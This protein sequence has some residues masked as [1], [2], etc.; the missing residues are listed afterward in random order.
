MKK[1][2]FSKPLIFFFWEGRCD[3]GCRYW[4]CG[5]EQKY[6][7]SWLKRTKTL[8]RF[9]LTQG[10]WTA[11]FF[12]TPCQWKCFATCFRN[13]DILPINS[14]TPYNSAASRAVFLIPKISH[15]IRHCKFV[16][17][18]GCVFLK[19]TQT[20]CSFQMGTK[21]P[22]KKI[23]IVVRSFFT[24]WTTANEKC[25]RTHGIMNSFIFQCVF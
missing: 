16:L 20:T 15:V 23:F 17:P 5:K 4:I 2:M 14:V 6:H 18:G 9:S 25:T 13:H 10:P 24:S 12:N 7:S 11:Y 3:G 19:K 8:T 22:T 1:K 21:N